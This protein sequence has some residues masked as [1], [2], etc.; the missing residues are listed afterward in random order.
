MAIPPKRT[1][2][3]TPSDLIV[4]V[5]A[6]AIGLAAASLRWHG[7]VRAAGAT[8]LPAGS[9]VRPRNIFPPPMPDALKRYHPRPPHLA[10]VPP[11]VATAALATE[12]ALFRAYRARDF[13]AAARLLFASRTHDPTTMARSMADDLPAH[14]P[15]LVDYKTVHFRPVVWTDDHLIIVT[16]E[17]TAPT[18][19]EASP[20]LGEVAHAKHAAGEVYYGFSVL[21][22]VDGRYLIFSTEVRNHPPAF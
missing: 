8:P 20:V 4:A 2:S 13:A 16:F 7:P 9:A 22:S 10:L 19:Q 3:R 15:E 21:R 18:P 12:S 11:P 14:D 5:A 6:C 1:R 17:L